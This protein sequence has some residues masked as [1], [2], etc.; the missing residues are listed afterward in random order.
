MKMI[1]QKHMKIVVVEVERKRNQKE[2][3]KIMKIPVDLYQDMTNL[4]LW[5]N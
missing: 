2:N 3:L 1:D 4:R 5:I